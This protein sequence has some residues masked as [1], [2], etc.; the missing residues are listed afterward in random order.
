[1]VKKWPNVPEEKRKRIFAYNMEKAK[2][3]EAAADFAK[4]LSLLPPG[5]AKQL[6]K[7]EERAAILAKY[8]ITGS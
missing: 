5:I 4:F 2:N 1:M 7:D 3:A 8:G 6:K